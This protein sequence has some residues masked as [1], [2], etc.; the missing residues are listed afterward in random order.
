MTDEEFREQHKP[1]QVAASY[2]EA[3]TVS[4]K[5]IFALADIGEGTSEDVIRHL[6]Q[7]D[8]EADHKNMI[9]ETHRVLTELYE[10]GR[11]TGHEENGDLVYNLH[12][13]TQANDGSVN[14]DLLAPGLD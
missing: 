9:A 5:I 7:L 11:V 13:I 10:G 12:K 14:P 4:D 1:L 8:P 3:Q 2:Q 6:E